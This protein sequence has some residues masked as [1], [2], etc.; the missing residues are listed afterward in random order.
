MK[1]IDNFLERNQFQLLSDT[2][3]GNEF[4]WYYNSDSI[5]GTSL[6]KKSIPLFAHRFF[7]DGVYYKPFDI[8][9]P[10]LRKLKMKE[11]IRIKA[12]L[13]MKT[14]FTRNIGWHVDFEPPYTKDQKTAI[15]YINDNNGYTRVKGYGKV[16]SVANRIVIFDPHI[17]HAGYTCTNEKTRVMVNFNYV[18]S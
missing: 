7:H 16:K 18:Q 13:N 4:P 9:E 17:P 14:L 11:L 3:M 10:C 15:L 5:Y 1:V 12:N 8:V 2:L 6:N